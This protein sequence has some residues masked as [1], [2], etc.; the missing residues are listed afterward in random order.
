M[1]TVVGGF[2]DDVAPGH[3]KWVYSEVENIARTQVIT[4]CVKRR[5]ELSLCILL[6]NRGR[7]SSH[8]DDDTFQRCR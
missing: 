6:R 5:V 8:R 4:P 3:A 7:T 1:V 2:A